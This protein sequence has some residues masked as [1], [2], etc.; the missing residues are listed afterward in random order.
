MQRGS[1]MVNPFRLFVILADTPE[2]NNLLVATFANAQDAMRNVR[3]MR[4]DQPAYKF[5][6]VEYALKGNYS[7]A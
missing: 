2:A 4:K 7:I 1:E 3:R 6:V 5:R